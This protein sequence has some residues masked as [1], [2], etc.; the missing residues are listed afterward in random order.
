MNDTMLREQAEERLLTAELAD[1]LQAAVAPGVDRR[2]SWRQLVVAALVVLGTAVTLGVAWLARTPDAMAQDPPFD[3][4]TPWYEQEWPFRG[5]WV[6]ALTH[7]VSVASTPAEVDEFVLT[8][9][10]EDCSELAAALERP[11][12]RRLSLSW[13][14]ESAAA[15]LSDALWQRLTAREDLEV[16]QL[17]GPFALPPARLRELRRLPRLRSLMLD[18]AGVALDRATGEALAE[19]PLLRGLFLVSMKLTADGLRVLGALPHLE[20]LALSHPTGDVAAWAAALP[21]LRSVRALVLEEQGSEPFLGA[22]RLKHLRDLPRLVAL[23]VCFA[24]FDDAA[25]AALP[26][27]LELLGLSGLDRCTAA[28]LGALSRLRALRTL[29]LRKALPDELQPAMYDAIRAL[30]LAR[31]DLLVGTA[32]ARFWQQMQRLPALRRVAVRPGMAQASVFAGAAACRQLEELTVWCMR[33]PPPEQLAVLR[34]HA[35]LRRLVF[36]SDEHGPTPFDAAQLAAL[37]ASIAV[38]IDV[39]LR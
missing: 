20:V 12:L 9:R 38:P 11:V 14:N 26:P 3:A 30:P 25:L 31:V 10:D 36:A 2:R 33:L 19:L 29:R 22:G 27:G 34:D 8:V 6:T 7:P 23:D 32:D 5:G 35:T 4:V 39:Q 28:G 37:R 17:M 16:L 21:H 24:D 13:R 1:V 18:G 15:N